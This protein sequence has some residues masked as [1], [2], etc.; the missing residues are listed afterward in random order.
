M[1]QLNSEDIYNVSGGFWL[2]VAAGIA[3]YDAATD[4]IKGF[5]EGIN[6]N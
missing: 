1:Q 6:A 3:I 2:Q 4:F 5:S